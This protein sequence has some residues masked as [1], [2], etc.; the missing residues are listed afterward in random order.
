[1]ADTKSSKGLSKQ[2]STFVQEFFLSHSTLGL[3]QVLYIYC[4][5]VS[6]GGRSPVWV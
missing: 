5:F 1:M 2:S 3:M 4:I 6:G